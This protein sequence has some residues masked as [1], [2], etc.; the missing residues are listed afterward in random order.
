MDPATV[1]RLDHLLGTR[2]AAARSLGGQH[3]VRHYRLSLTDGRE[4]FAKVGNGPA[5][6]DAAARGFASEAAGLRWLGE[7]QSAGVPYV[8]TDTADCL[9]IG[10]IEESPPSR[11]AA[12]RFGR[13]LAGLHAAGADQFG[14]PV[15]QWRF[16]AGQSFKGVLVYDPA[17]VGFSWDYIS[18]PDWSLTFHY[19]PL[20]SLS[21]TV[22]L[23]GGHYHYDVPTQGLTND[24]FGYILTKVD[25]QS[26]PR[27]DY[28]SRTSLGEMTGEILI[29][30]ALL[31]IERSGIPERVSGK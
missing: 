16:A 3:G 28:V 14:A 25:F 23:P 4:V 10:W 1:S 11:D 12:A 24:A 27:Y 31:M 19:S 26:F 13:E 9:V 18:Q 30:N 20:V 21:F 22:D 17:V 7:A 6:P 15:P 8:L 2:V 5:G 29:E